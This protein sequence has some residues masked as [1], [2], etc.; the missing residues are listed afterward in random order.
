MDGYEA[1]DIGDLAKNKPSI[2]QDWGRYVTQKRKYEIL[3]GNVGFNSIDSAV[4]DLKSEI[5]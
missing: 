5:G 1:K 3:E 2:R 4:E